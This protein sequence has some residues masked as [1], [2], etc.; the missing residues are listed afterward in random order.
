MLLIPASVL[1]LCY[2]L[3]LFMRR[4]ECMREKTV[5]MY[6][7][8]IGIVLLMS[9]IM[10]V[11]LVMTFMAYYSFFS[12]RRIA[13]S[14]ACRHSVF[15]T[16]TKLVGWTAAVCNSTPCEFCIPMHPV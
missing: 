6:D 2:G 12:R 11:L 16:S 4:D 8:R 14:Q 1:V 15:Q 3:F 7:D 9:V 13:M 10:C 5:I